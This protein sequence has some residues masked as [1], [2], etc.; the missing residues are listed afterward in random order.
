MKE[1]ELK[2]SSWHYK[3][4]TVGSPEKVGELEYGVDLCK[5]IWMVIWAACMWVFM[6]W[7]GAGLCYGVGFSWYSVFNYFAFGEM[8]PEPAFIMLM[9]QGGFI[10]LFGSLALYV[11]FK[12]RQVYSTREPGFVVLSYRKFK[13]KTCSRINFK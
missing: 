13:E 3:L 9:L 1:F 7:M 2:K 6:I 11:W 10:A 4:V 5:Y 12:E 8:I